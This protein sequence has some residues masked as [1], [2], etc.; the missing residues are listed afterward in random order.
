MYK[1]KYSI[2]VFISCLFTQT[3]VEF[4]LGENK[5]LGRYEHNSIKG[6]LA[7]NAVIDIRNSGDSLYFFGTGNGLSYADILPDGTI[8][9]GYFSITAMPMGGN[10]ALAVSGNIIAVSGVIDTAVA[11][12][13]EPKGTGI[14]YSTDRGEHWVYLP[15]PVDPDTVYFDNYGLNECINND[16]DWDSQSETCF[17][18]KNWTIPWGGQEIKSLLVSSEVDNVSYDLA[19]Y[20]NFIY[21]ASWAGGLRRYPAGLPEGD[22]IRQWEVIPLPGDN[23]LDLYC[24]QIDSSYYL[25]PRDPGDGGNHNH[26]GFSVYVGDNTVWAGTAAGIN[27]GVISGNCINWVGHYTSLMNNIS[28]NWVIG[29]AQQEFADF[30]RLWAIT[31]AADSQ[32]EFRALSYTDDDGETWDTTQPAGFPEK[33]Y[34]LYGNSTRIWAASESGLYISE[35]GKHWEKYLRPIDKNSGEELIA[36]AV[37]SAYFSENNNWL[38]VGTGDGITISDDDGINWDVHRFW[39]PTVY[40]NEEKMISAYPN[41]FFIN[42]YNQVGSDGHVRFVYSNP[43]NY[44][45]TINIFDFAMDRV[46]QI[47]NSHLV[48]N[49]ESEVIW[50]GR[51]EYG[52]KVANGVYFC[53]LSLNGQT[54]WTKLAVIN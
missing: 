19:I 33:I 27:K 52:N 11:T 10:P 23:D 7:D 18:N 25:N 28:G 17:S 45:G 42:D 2:L 41:P 16:Y 3:P 48:N 39:E 13:I 6:Q 36:E 26:K 49:N 24:G 22:D 32:D 21:A 15:Q 47:N 50:N 46:I 8:D 4:Q 29:F 34:N 54:Y 31:W 14:A 9:F 43:E 53:R 40:E 30:N 35:D 44:S 12:G 20:D 5:K 38:W 1:I 37:M 51:N